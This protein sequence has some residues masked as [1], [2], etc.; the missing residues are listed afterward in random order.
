MPKIHERAQILAG[1]FFASK[2][3]YSP[4]SFLFTPCLLML[5]TLDVFFLLFFVNPVRDVQSFTRMLMALSFILD[6]TPVKGL[7]RILFESV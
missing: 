6:V 4:V 1:I 3:L 7:Y 2:Q 5:Y